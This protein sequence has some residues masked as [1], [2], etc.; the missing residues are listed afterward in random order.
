MLEFQL[1]DKHVALLRRLNFHWRAPLD[2]TQYITPAVNAIRPLGNSDMWTDVAE[3][4]GVRI[5]NWDLDELWTKEEWAQLEAFYDETLAALQIMVQHGALVPGTYTPDGMGG[6]QDQRQELRLTLRQVE[7]EMKQATWGEDP[8][9]A[10][11]NNALE[12]LRGLVKT[13]YGG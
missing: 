7:C 3:I 2:V 1:T 5:P 12:R 11:F 8:D 6:W 4:L 13:L 10:A 9:S